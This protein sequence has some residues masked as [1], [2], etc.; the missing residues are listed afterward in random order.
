MLMKFL[1]KTLPV[2]VLVIGIVFFCFCLGQASDKSELEGTWKD[3]H[4][5]WS[6]V[7]S[8][9]QVTMKSPNPQMW[10]EGTFKSDPSAD[11]KEIDLA[12]EKSGIPAYQGLT[13]L[14]IYK[15]EGSLLTLALGEPGKNT[16]PESFGSGTG[17]MIFSL[18]REQQD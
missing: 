11:P 16:R 7:F 15:I 6:F 10:I 12:I 9:N 2:S 3:L 4:Q 8:D 17:A 1:S 13:S 5:G 14:G 18:T